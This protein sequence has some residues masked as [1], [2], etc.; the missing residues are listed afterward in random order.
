MTEEQGELL[1]G[2][3]VL[4]VDDNAD[5][6]TAVCVLIGQSF[7]CAVLSASSYD[8][9]LQILDSGAHVDLVFSDVVMPKTDGLALARAIR[10]RWPDL[11]VV[12]T[13]GFPEA[14]DSVIE[15]GAIALIKPYSTEQLAAIL[16]EQLHVGGRS[17]S[18][19]GNAL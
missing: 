9:A 4:V 7:G 18:A 14:V 19:N 8:G 12:L 17:R 11:P 15:S 2:F 5:A 16:S 10:Q 6:L 13:T 1:R 3:A